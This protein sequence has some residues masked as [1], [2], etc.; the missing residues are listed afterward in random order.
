MKMNFRRAFTLIE[1]LVVIAIIAILIG[2][3]LPAVQKVREAAGRTQCINNMHQV[4]IALHAFH[5]ERDRLPVGM[6]SDTPQ[7][8]VKLKRPPQYP[9]AKFKEYWPWFVF[10]LPQLEKGDVY[11][12]YINFNLWPWWQGVGFM[13]TVQTIQGPATSTHNGI[14]MKA[15][16]CPYDARSEYV[17][18]DGGMAVALTGYLGVNGTD[19]FAQNGVFAPNRAASFGDIADGT[20]NTIVVGEK[21]PTLDMVY[22]WWYAGAGAASSAGQIGTSDVILGAAERHPSAGSVPQV[23]RPGKLADPT[24]IYQFNFWSTHPNGAVFLMGDGS[25]RFITYGGG[26]SILAALSTIAGGEPV[27][28]D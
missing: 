24:N 7:P 17:A 23:Y 3:L 27:S 25:A 2:L 19:Q 1:L 16:Q 28:L 6:I 10:I 9:S 13:G 22:G 4:G 8:S 26:K 21:P 20:S 18:S 12:K 11:S 15:Y 5:N 14:P